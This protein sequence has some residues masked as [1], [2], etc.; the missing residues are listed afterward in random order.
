MKQLLGEFS[1]TRVGV[2]MLI[3]RV[4]TGVAMMIHGKGKV[5]R[6]GEF[7]MFNWMGPDSTTPGIMQFIASFSEFFG[8]L[9]LV[10]GL[11][12]PLAALGIAATMLGAI[13]IAHA[14][15]PWIDTKGGRSF[16][17]ASLFLLSSLVL[18]ILGAGRYS[19]DA[20]LFGRERGGRGIT[21]KL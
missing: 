10:V 7:V 15:D 2:A 17:M 21:G 1:S 16:E 19:L 8:G 5:M 11:L 20:L 14:G 18:M 4:V 3:L 12:T 6:D 13:F 9:A